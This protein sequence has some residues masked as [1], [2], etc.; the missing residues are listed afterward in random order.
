MAAS[1]DA[2]VRNL[3]AYVSVFFDCENRQQQIQDALAAHR[4]VTI[5]GFGGCGKTRVAVEVARAAPGFEMVAFASL[6]ECLEA[7]QIAQRIRVALRVP[8]SH[9]DTSHEDTLAQLCTF[10]DGRDVLLVL[11]NFE[12]L[13]D[14]GGAAVVVDLLARLPRLRCLVTTRRV[15]D[16]A[17]ECEVAIGPLPLPSASMGLAEAAG[18]ASVALFIDRARGVRPDFALTARNAPALIE[19]SQALEGLPLAIEIA[20]SRVRAYSPTEMQAALAQRFELLARHGPRAARHGRHASL[21]AAVDWSWQLL[22][23]AQQRLLAALSVFRGGWTASTAESVCR[24]VGA[25]R[26]LDALV[27]DSLLRTDVDVDGT[28]RFSMLETI[29]E[30]ARERLGDDAPALRARH[31]A[32]YLRV[33]RLTQDTGSALPQAELPNLIEALQSAVDDADPGTAL[34]IAVALRA[35]WEACGMPPVVLRLLHRAAMALN[36]GDSAQAHAYATEALALAGDDPARRAAALAS[37]ALVTWERETL[38]EPVRPLLDEALALSIASHALQVQADSLR[39]MATVVLRHGAEDADYALADRLFEQAEALYHRTGQPTW[40]HRVMLS[41]AGCLTGLQ[42]YA[43]AAQVL[44]ACERHFTASRSWADLIVLAN[45]RGYLESGQLHWPEALAAG[46]RC[47]Q[48]AWERHARLWLVTALWNLPQ[49]LA[50]LGEVATA[51][52]L[53]SFS[54]HFWERHIGVLSADDIDSVQSLRRHA[55]EALGSEQTAGLWDAGARLSL[56]EAVRLALG[57]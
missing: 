7:S 46:R 17:G 32:H 49:P 25:H 36:D 38:A 1:R 37:L 12:Q 34:A 18:I 10:L 53:K 52:M 23:P 4:L 35:H 30:F 16:V 51:A 55:V 41:R 14:G 6:A 19:L 29:R 39:V 42:R 48:L 47:V 9:E 2:P 13:V 20:A 57:A 31:R 5:S 43:D 15:L 26:R 27:A 33:S 3:P 11:D 56:Q 50:R 44:E 28:T 21:H 24:A 40:A 22:A 54:A 8:A 45:M